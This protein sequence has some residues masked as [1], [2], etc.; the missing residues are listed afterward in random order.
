MRQNRREKVRW[1]ADEE[2]RVRGV[3]VIDEDEAIGIVC[4]LA[5]AGRAAGL[6]RGGVRGNR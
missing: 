4:S 2:T 6:G 1:E 3:G 5:G